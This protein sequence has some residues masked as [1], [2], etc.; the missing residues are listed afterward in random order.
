MKIRDKCIIWRD[1]T[2]S[3]AHGFLDRNI[4][5]AFVCQIPDE[6][7]RVGW[8]VHTGCYFPRGYRE[9][10]DIDYVIFIQ[11]STRGRGEGG[12]GRPA[13][14]TARPPFWSWGSSLDPAGRG[15]RLPRPEI[16][17]F[18]ISTWILVSWIST[19]HRL[20]SSSSVFPHAEMLVPAQRVIFLQT[21]STGSFQCCGSTSGRIRKKFFQIWKL[22]GFLILLFSI[23]QNG[24]RLLWVKIKAGLAD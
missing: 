22:A 4:V 17:E 9:L 14:S 1:F 10:V 3:I 12:V 16:D 13:G 6:I 15:G 5:Q 20:F 11:S 19:G 24:Y 18:S 2:V 21:A 23:F 7:S 8:Y